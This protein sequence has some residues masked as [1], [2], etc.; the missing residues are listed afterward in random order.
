MMSEKLYH[1]RYLILSECLKKSYNTYDEIPESVKEW[2]CRSSN[3]KEITQ[4]SLYEI[5]DLIL[6]QYDVM[7]KEEW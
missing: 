2:I 4:L 3:I 5:N 7:G 6:W 1:R